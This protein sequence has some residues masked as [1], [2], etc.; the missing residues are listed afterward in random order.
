M[1]KVKSWF[2]S[3]VIGVIDQKQVKPMHFAVRD[4]VALGEQRLGAE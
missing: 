4:V 3:F 2:S 1:Q